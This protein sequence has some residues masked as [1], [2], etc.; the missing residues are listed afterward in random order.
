MRPTQR[1]SSNSWL[2]AQPFLRRPAW[3]RRGLLCVDDVRLGFQTLDRGRCYT[4]GFRHPNFHP[5]AADP[6][7]VWNIQSVDLASGIAT[8]AGLPG[9][10]RQ[11]AYNREDLVSLV[12]SQDVRRRGIRVEDLELISRRALDGAKAASAGKPVP[13]LLASREWVFNTWFIYGFILGSRR[14]EVCPD[15]LYASP[16][17]HRVHQLIYSRS[18][19]QQV[20]SARY[21]YN[22][23]R[24]F[25]SPSDRSDFLELFPEFAPCFAMYERFVSNVVDFLINPA[26]I[27]NGQE[28]VIA[29][30]ILA[31][32]KRT[33][34]IFSISN[35]S[36]RDIVYDFVVC[37]EHVV[38]YLNALAGWYHKDARSAL[39]W[40]QWSYVW[41]PPGG[42]AGPIVLVPG[43]LFWTRRGAGVGFRRVVPEPHVR[44]RSIFF[45]PAVKTL[46]G[47]SVGVP[48]DLSTPDVFCL[49][50]N[51]HRKVVQNPQA[52]ERREW[53]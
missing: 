50:S 36:Q 26:E 38:L 12:G 40:A 22:S 24:A 25:L 3:L 52:T 37:P 4:I 10:P 19:P 7:G 11:A 21:Q 1:C 18:P 14:P 9:I 23:L 51:R 49:S 46:L 28:G 27:K 48:I 32:I 5:M 45:V 41:G 35:K 39:N 30:T 44:R 34:R 31:R 43:R 20:Q 53:L 47:H 42:G 33:E 2:I 15:V 29:Q 8:A 17:L 13:R 16:L 6:L